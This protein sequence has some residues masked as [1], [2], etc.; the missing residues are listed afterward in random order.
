MTREKVKHLNWVEKI[1]VSVICDEVQPKIQEACE[2]AC[3]GCKFDRPSQREH[4]C[5]QDT[6]DDKVEYFLWDA[7]GMTCSQRVMD[8]WVSILQRYPHGPT[9]MEASHMAEDVLPL[10]LMLNL[11][12]SLLDAVQILLHTDQIFTSAATAAPPPSPEAA[13]DGPMQLSD[14]EHRDTD[15]PL[16]LEELGGYNF[17]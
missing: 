4:D 11:N 8:T 6:W 5:I 1:L 9:E 7:V 15:Q 10:E 3:H 16:H 12:P 13:E 14:L 2:A 17:V